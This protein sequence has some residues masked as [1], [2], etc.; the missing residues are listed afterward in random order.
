MGGAVRAK[1]TLPSGRKVKI[2]SSWGKVTSCLLPK[3][4]DGWVGKAACSFGF[5]AFSIS[6]VTAG[7][8]SG[9]PFA[10]AASTNACT[11]ARR[12]NAAY[13]AQTLS[14]LPQKT[15]SSSFKPAYGGV[16]GLPVRSTRAAQ[17]WLTALVVT[18]PNAATMA[19][20]F[21]WKASVGG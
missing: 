3:L 20:S 17:R 7:W 14:M 8:T 2:L 11:W 18:G 5:Q 19:G 16:V 21:T 10:A 13:I 9:A 4:S 15:I 12:A 6:S 1:S